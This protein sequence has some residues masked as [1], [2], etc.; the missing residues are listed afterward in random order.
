MLLYNEMLTTTPEEILR[1][2]GRTQKEQALFA[3]VAKTIDPNKKAVAVF[4]DIK[5]D[6]PTAQNLI[7]DAKKHLEAIRQFSRR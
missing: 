7:P 3:E 5:K 1:W 2:N 6:H 4:E